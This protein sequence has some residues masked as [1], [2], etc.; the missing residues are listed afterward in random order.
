M[1]EML[2]KLTIFPENHNIKIGNKSSESVAKFRYLG[3]TL[4]DHNCIMETLR[5]E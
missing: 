5:E 2:R 1:I 3:T 4:I